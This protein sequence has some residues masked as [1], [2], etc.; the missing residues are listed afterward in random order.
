MNASDPQSL[1]HFDDQGRPRMVDVG[2]KPIS[3]RRAV[4]RGRLHLSDNGW[5]A[6]QNPAESL[7]GEVLPVAQV[8]AVQAAKR[9]SEWIPLA[10]PLPLTGVEVRWEKDGQTRILRIEVE[11]RTIAR[12]GVEMEALTAVAAGLLTVYD[13]LKG[14]DRSMVLGPIWLHRKEGGRSGLHRYEDPSWG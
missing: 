6:L 8:A 12:T 4:A 1:D 5:K 14:V 13:M 7:K 2:E 9:S 10:H 11:V 3:D